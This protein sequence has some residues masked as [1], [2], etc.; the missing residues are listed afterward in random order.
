[1]E[2]MHNSDK[3]SKSFQGPKV[4]PGPQPIRAHFVDAIS[5]HKVSKMVQNF[6]FGPPFT[7]SWLQP[8]QT[9]LYFNAIVV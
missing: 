5:L 6:G 3:K 7:K 8:C 9:L 2:R 1:M 4:G